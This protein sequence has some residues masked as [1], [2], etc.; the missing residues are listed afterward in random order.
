MQNEDIKPIGFGGRKAAVQQG[1]EIKEPSN[2]KANGWARAI[3]AAIG[4]SLIVF[5]TVALGKMDA[6]IARG[7]S[8]RAELIKAEAEIAT[9]ED[10]VRFYDEREAEAQS[11]GN[12]EIFWSLC[13][14]FGGVFGIAM[15]TTSLGPIREDI[16]GLVASLP[17][18]AWSFLHGNKDRLSDLE[19]RCAD[20]D[21]RRTAFHD[22]R[23]AFSGDLDK[24]Y[25]N[26]MDQFREERAALESEAV[27]LLDEFREAI[28]WDLRRLRFADDCSSLATIRQKLKARHG[29]RL[30]TNTVHI[31]QDIAE[32]LLH[33]RLIDE[34]T[35]TGMPMTFLTLA[36]PLDKRYAPKHTEPALSCPDSTVL[37]P[38]TRWVR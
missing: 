14:L 15:V 11:L 38:D 25:L 22:A 16:H 8:M 4:C 17:G 5:A 27:A 34:Q 18:S 24:A 32:G 36:S 2:S 7:Y 13:V 33:R 12:W 20:F 28:G 19:A 21:A 30:S 29:E 23:S 26:A 3:L 6:T 37:S 9:T 31:S 10:A 35:E 1:Y